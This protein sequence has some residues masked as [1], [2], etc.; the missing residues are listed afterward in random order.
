MKINSL[1]VIAAGCVLFATPTLANPD[2]IN[3]TFAMPETFAALDKNRDK[4][5]DRNEL[6]LFGIYGLTIDEIYARFDVDGNQSISE[7][8]FNGMQDYLNLK[9]LSKRRSTKP[10]TTA[11]WSEKTKTT[12]KDIIVSENVY[13]ANIDRWARL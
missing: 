9:A 7:P 12:T 8:E 5:L 10:L 13:S 6:T 4:T 2:L 3:S 11:I 1:K